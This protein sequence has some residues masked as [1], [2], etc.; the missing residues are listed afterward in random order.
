MRGLDYF[1]RGLVK[2]IRRVNSGVRAVVTGTYDYDVSIETDDVGRAIGFS[3]DCPYA[4]DGLYCKHMAALLYWLDEVGCKDTTLPADEIRGLVDGLP[5]EKL[6]AFLSDA[7]A[8][9]PTLLEEFQRRFDFPGEDVFLTQAEQTL[10]HIFQRYQDTYG[11]ISCRAAAHFRTDVADFLADCVQD[12]V[13]SAEELLA[14]R[15]LGDL[16]NRLSVL[17][18]DDSKGE[19]GDLAARIY[20]LWEQIVRQVEGSEK[21]AV[22]EW[23]KSKMGDPGDNDYLF[24]QAAAFF[25]E[26]FLEEEF[27]REKLTLVNHKIEFLKDNRPPAEYSWSFDYTLGNSVLEKIGLMKNLGY[28]EGEIEN[29]RREFWQLPGVRKSQVA[30]YLKQG[31]V[32]AAEAVLLASKEMDKEWPGLVADYRNLLVQIYR[33]QGKDELLKQELWE[34]ANTSRSLNLAGFLELKDLYSPQEWVIVR[35]KVFEAQKDRGPLFEFFAA[36]NLYSRI[37]ADIRENVGRLNNLYRLEAY[38]SPLKKRY[39][40]AVLEVF[41]AEVEQAAVKASNRQVYRDLARLLRKMETYPQGPEVV[42]KIVAGWRDKYS[43]RPA[44]QDELSRGGF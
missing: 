29:F 16:Y 42:E 11:F 33:E 23:F 27:C 32:N 39:P 26:G 19:I 12:L 8:A 31:D 17:D 3:C 6:R 21:R 15:I 43:R 9:N 24:E 36:E 22:F 7:L 10:D 14:F 41:R 35:E 18:I 5:E 13:E 2:N 1:E 30:A 37:L 28:P 25:Q 40:K 38:E 34:I 4:A 20:E 44:L